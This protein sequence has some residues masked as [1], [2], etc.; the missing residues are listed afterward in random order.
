MIR[1]VGTRAGVEEDVRRL[2]VPMHEPARVRRVESARELRDDADRLPGLETAAFEALLEV[3]PLDVAHRDEEDV[4]GARGLVDRNDVRVVDRRGELGLAQEPLPEGVVLGEAGVH[5]LQRHPSLEPE[6][7]GEVDD[8]HPARAQQ[9]LDP[10]AGEL[11]ADP[12]VVAHL[13]VDILAFRACSNDR[14][15]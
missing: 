6:V 14:P 13:H 11:G 4:L 15:S 3:A 8:A 7:V 10:V 12:R 5:Q 1:A 9:R 2:H